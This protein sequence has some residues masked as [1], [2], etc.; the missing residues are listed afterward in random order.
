MLCLDNENYGKV[1][2]GSNGSADWILTQFKAIKDTSVVLTINEM[3][4]VYVG[5]VDQFKS[6][7][8]VVTSISRDSEYDMVLNPTI[9]ALSSITHGC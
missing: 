1:R 3:L 9:D 6:S 5:K 4:R 8:T 7:D 2:A